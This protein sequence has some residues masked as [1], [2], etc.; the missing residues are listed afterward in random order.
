MPE[1]QLIPYT[2]EGHTLHYAVED[3][4]LWFVFKE[5]A[6]A[7]GYST[8][9]SFLVDHVPAEW[10]GNK[11]IGTP[12]GPQSVTCL[13][14]AGLF[15]FLNRSDK[16]RALPFQKKVAGEIL[17]SIR[18][19]G[20]YSIHGQLSFDLDN[21]EHLLALV[22]ETAKKVL[23]LKGKVTELTA[24]NQVLAQENKTLT[25]ELEELK[26][27]LQPF[28][29]TDGLIRLQQAAYALGY[30]HPNVCIKEWIRARILYRH[31][32]HVRSYQE[33]IERGFFRMRVVKATTPHSD[34]TDRV[35]SQAFMT[36]DGAVWLA[37]PATRLKYGLSDPPPR[38]RTEVEQLKLDQIAG[39]KVTPELPHHVPVPRIVR[40]ET[41]ST[42]P[43]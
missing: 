40:G 38:K 14:E 26:K 3:G 24:S 23:E 33:Y 32:K 34:G 35:V 7:L 4:D 11:R 2:F 25:D 37:D 41:V 39:A 22:G 29:E 27:R 42:E 10:K 43:N 9:N 20:S 1:V 30:V 17:P 36:I 6:L 16:P 21:K 18:R 13:S 31:G 12:G 15:F 19:T 8:A 5:V 28:L